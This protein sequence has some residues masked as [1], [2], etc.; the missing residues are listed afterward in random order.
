MVGG[1]G[2][3]LRRVVRRRR[4]NCRYRRRDD[5]LRASRIRGRLHD[6]PRAGD[7]YVDRL[8]EVAPSET[9]REVDHNVKRTV[10]INC[11]RDRR[12]VLEVGLDRRHVFYFSRAA[13]KTHDA[14]TLLRE[15]LREL[16]AEPACCP[17]D[18]DLHVVVCTNHSSQSREL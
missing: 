15:F 1:D 7:V 9:P 12:A 17:S 14:V 11:A 3:A 18:E 2:H 13:R 6:A 10:F 16:A 8:R 4:A 5:E